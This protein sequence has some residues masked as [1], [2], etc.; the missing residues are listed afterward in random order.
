MAVLDFF[1]KSVQKALTAPIKNST[2]ATED[3]A[4]GSTSS[5]PLLTTILAGLPAE[6]TKAGKDLD[7]LLGFVRLVLLGFIGHSASK[8]APEQLVAELS[9]VL[10]GKNKSVKEALSFLKDCIAALGG[11]GKVALVAREVEVLSARSPIKDNVFVIA[12]GELALLEQ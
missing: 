7:A 8:D 2:S 9:K 1:E 10:D 12:G 11:D 4:P 6:I 5:S 3:I